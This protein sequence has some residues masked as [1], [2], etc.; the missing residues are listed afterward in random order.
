MFHT[1]ILCLMLCIC[2]AQN[3]LISNWRFS[4]SNTSV[5]CFFFKCEKPEALLLV[6]LG[7]YYHHHLTILSL[8]LTWKRIAKKCCI[9]YFI[10]CPRIRFPKFFTVQFPYVLWNYQ[11][12]ILKKV[13]KFE[14]MCSKNIS[15]NWSSK[16]SCTHQKSWLTKWTPRTTTQWEN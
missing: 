1:S 7:D 4:F 5:G 12:K 8:T 9:I 11:A 13:I 3:E 6:L 14:T 16:C 15:L 2:P 10:L